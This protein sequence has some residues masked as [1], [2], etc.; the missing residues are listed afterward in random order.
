MLLLNGTMHPIQDMTITRVTILLLNDAVG[1]KRY[2]RS[3]TITI[4]LLSTGI[5]VRVAP[6]LDQPF[7]P[8]PPKEYCTKRKEAH[9]MEPLGARNGPVSKDQE[10]GS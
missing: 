10:I 8:F 2:P 5:F 4:F 6:S 1:A 9:L 7:S 3:G